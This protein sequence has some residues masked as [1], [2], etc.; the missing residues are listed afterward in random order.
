MNAAEMRKHY[1][2]CE[3]LLG[4]RLALSALHLSISIMG[5]GQGQ[6]RAGHG[7]ASV[8]TVATTNT[9]KRT[10]R[11]GMQRISSDTVGR[12]ARGS[13]VFI[14]GNYSPFTMGRDCIQTRKLPER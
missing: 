2:T 8:S 9:C 10:A 4:C 1:L 3:I 12:P 7:N 6:G 11:I 13:V 14:I 5:G